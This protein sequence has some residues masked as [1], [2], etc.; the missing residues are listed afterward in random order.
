MDVLVKIQIKKNLYF[1]CLIEIIAVYFHLKIVV[2]YYKKIVKVQQ[3][4]NVLFIKDCFM[5]RIIY[6]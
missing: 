4:Y 2:F 3:E 6:Y 5:E 1:L